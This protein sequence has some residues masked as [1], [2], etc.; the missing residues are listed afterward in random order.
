MHVK[1]MTQGRELGTLL[2]F[3]IADIVPSYCRWFRAV[4]ATRL[5]RRCRSGREPSFSSSNVPACKRQS[6]QG[7]ELEERTSTLTSGLPM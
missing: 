2:G 3:E 7:A 5:A 1:L 4:Q 6:R